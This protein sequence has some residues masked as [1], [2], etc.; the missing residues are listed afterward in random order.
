MLLPL[1]KVFIGK[2][3]SAWINLSK[4][5]QIIMFQ[6]VPIN[7][8]IYKHTEHRIFFSGAKWKSNNI[9]NTWSYAKK[10]SSTL[11]YHNHK[12]KEKVA[13]AFHSTKPDMIHTVNVVHK[14]NSKMKF[15]IKE[16]IKPFTKKRGKTTIGVNKW[17][18]CR[19]MIM[20]ENMELL[21]IET[22]SQ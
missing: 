12:Q 8:D 15:L 22:L 11:V 6:Q 21:S 7:F 16:I 2:F 18:L 14:T 4:L 3:I 19:K 1:L 10:T 20:L 5:L 17:T 9:I 13:E